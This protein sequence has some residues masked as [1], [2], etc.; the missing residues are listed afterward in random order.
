M[1]TGRAG[2][3]PRLDGLAAR[4]RL[5][6]VRADA[7]LGLAWRGLDRR[8]R[9]GSP[10]AG[11][12]AYLQAVAALPRRGLSRRRSADAGGGC[13]HHRSRLAARAAPT[14]IGPA[15]IGAGGGGEWRR[16]RPRRLAVE[17]SRRARRR[18]SD[19]GARELAPAAS[20][21]RGQARDEPEPEP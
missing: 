1:T 8:A 15:G 16:R 20:L 10:A 17:P 5:A 2:V 21:V 18:L 11:E 13:V 9:L 19:Q 12:P 7:G 6:L 3:A 4:A 14:G